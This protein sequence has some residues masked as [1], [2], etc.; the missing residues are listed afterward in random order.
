MT[1][2]RLNGT[3]I[4]DEASF[5]QE[6]RRA[7]GFPSFYG[8]NWN[9]WIDCMSYVDDPPAQMSAI[10]VGDDDR[11]EV[12]VTGTSDLWERCPDVLRALVECT[13]TVNERF[14]SS[15]SE[16]RICL[17]FLDRGPG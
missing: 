6:C 10:H 7:L 9:A 13:A 5:H 3:A 14:A 15:G 8:G 16:T 2:V 11:L 4:R 17:T 12:E 1:K